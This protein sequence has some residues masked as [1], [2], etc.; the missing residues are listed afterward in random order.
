MIKFKDQE[1]IVNAIGDETRTFLANRNVESVA[2]FG[3]DFVI[4]AEAEDVDLPRYSWLHLWRINGS[5]A[6]RV[7]DSDV[8]EMEVSVVKAIGHNF[9]AAI[10]FFNSLAVVFEV[11]QNRSFQKLFTFRKSV[12]DLIA[13]NEQEI[14]IC[15][16]SSIYVY[17]NEGKVLKEIRCEDFLSAESFPFVSFFWV[18]AGQLGLFSPRYISVLVQVI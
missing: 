5:N 15:D 18:R 14:A 6:V 13:L 9:V 7:A 12:E 17:S 16:S 2:K 8:I 10:D 11:S 1:L 4:S 3:D